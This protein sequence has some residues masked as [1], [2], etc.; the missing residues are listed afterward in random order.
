M[1][2]IAMLWQSVDC[3]LA[4]TSGVHNA[5]GAVKAIL[6]G[7]NAVQVC[8]VLYKQGPRA[9]SVIVDGISDWMDR[10][11][12]ESLADFRGRLSQPAGSEHRGFARAQYI[13]A[14]V[15]ME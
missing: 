5:E 14:F 7:A 6:A 15:G 11:G 3:D 10:H 1:R 9:V 13:K 4:L 8:S 12:F 2:W